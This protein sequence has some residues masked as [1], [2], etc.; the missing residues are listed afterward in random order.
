MVAVVVLPW[1]PATA[2]RPLAAWR[3]PTGRPSAAPPRAPR[4]RPPPCSSRLVS[5]HGRRI[6][7][8]VGVGA[9]V[10]TVA[11]APLQPPSASRRAVTGE[12]FMIAARHAARYHAHQARWRWRS[13]PPR[14]CRPRAPQRARQV[15]HHHRGG[16][17]VEAGGGL[18]AGGSGG[19]AHP[20]ARPC[21]SAASGRPRARAAAPMA[22]RRAGSAA[23]PVQDRGPGSRRRSRSSATSTAPHRRPPG[24]G[25]W[26]S[27]GPPGRP[28]AGTSTDGVP[29][30]VNSATVTAPARPTTTSAALVVGDHLVL[31]QHPPPH[32]P[33][34]FVIHGVA[35][36][37]G[38]APSPTP[39][40]SVVAARAPVT[41]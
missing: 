26:R 6:R 9:V 3:S 1:V 12:D 36:A 4:A 33:A 37:D 21:A 29:V 11:D 15:R 35:G 22:P 30:T 2:T 7:Q 32:Q 31:E 38:P 41:W 19:M 13:S 23:S 18:A 20:P 16:D 34:M 39:R 14:R 8:Q 10:R 28:A 17:G 27:G 5:G 24:P 25:R 40:H